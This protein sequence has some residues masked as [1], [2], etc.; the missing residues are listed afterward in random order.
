MKQIFKIFFL[1][2]FAYALAVQ[3]ATAQFEGEV[4]FVIQNPGSQLGETSNVNLTFT[5]NRIF[6]DS[7]VSLNVMAGLSARGILVRNDLNDFVVITTDDEG[8]KVEKN[9]LDGL[10]SL[11]NQVQGKQPSAERKPFPWDEKVEETG[12][13]KKIRGYTVHEFILKGDNPGERTSVWLTDQIRVNWGLLLDAWYTTGSTQFDHEIPIEMVMNSNS[14]PLLVEVYR[15]DEILMRTEAMSVDDQNFNR[16][17]T[18]LPSNIR[19]IGL[20]DLMMN[21]FRQQR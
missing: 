11:M 12:E 2:L 7:N 10:V 8:L 9:E 1:M 16:S 20:T 19:V 18:E 15:N 4:H 3:P 14:F 13:T 6:V 17:K 5:N 21:F